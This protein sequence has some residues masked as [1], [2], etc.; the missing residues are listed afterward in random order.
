MRD[1]WEIVRACTQ[2]SDNEDGNGTNVLTSYL[3]LTLFNL[4]YD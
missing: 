2:T 4:R 3:F 1:I